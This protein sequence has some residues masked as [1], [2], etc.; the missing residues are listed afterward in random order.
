MSVETLSPD[1]KADI[2]ELRRLK[3]LVII[4]HN[5]EPCVYLYHDFAVCERLGVKVW[6]SKK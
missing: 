4:L 6:R 2:D 1:P 3:D 5:C